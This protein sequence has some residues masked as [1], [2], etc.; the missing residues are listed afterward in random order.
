MVFARSFERTTPA[1]KNQSKRCSYGR[2]W[3]ASAGT[4]T[5]ACLCYITPPGEEASAKPVTI[6]PLPHMYVI[7]DLV[8]DMTNFYDQRARRAGDVA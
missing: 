2:D 7:K 3:V 5:L 8:P 4:N 6:N 1:C